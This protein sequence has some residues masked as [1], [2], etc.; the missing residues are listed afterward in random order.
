MDLQTIW[1]SAK[2]DG[3][4]LQRLDLFP[5]TTSAPVYGRESP[6]MDVI[7]VPDFELRKKKQNQMA[8]LLEVL[9]TTV[10][11]ARVFQFSQIFRRQT[12]SVWH[13]IVEAGDELVK[14]LEDTLDYV[15]TI[16]PLL[17]VSYGLGG[18]VLKKALHT[19]ELKD[20]PTSTMIRLAQ[21]GIV[22][23][24]VP[25]LTEHR[26]DLWSNLNTI[27]EVYGRFNNSY[28]GSKQD[29]LPLMADV[30]M[31]F[32]GLGSRSRILTVY[33]SEP[34]KVRTFPPKKKLLLGIGLAVLNMR[35]ETPFCSPTD[36]HGI[37]QFSHG[38]GLYNEISRLI[39]ICASIHIQAQPNSGTITM[40]VPNQID[41]FGRSG[42][43]WA[44][45]ESYTES[46]IGEP[47]PSGSYD[48]T[49]QDSGSSE[50]WELVVAEKKI[51][52]MPCYVRKAIDKNRNFVGRS[53]IIREIDQALLP[54][55]SN[56]SSGPRS[57]S[58][59]GFGGLGKTQIATYYAFARES[60]FDAIFWVQADELMK[61]NKSFEDIAKA[62]DLVEEG[63]QGNK[64]ISRD[65]VLEWFCEP[66]KR[67]MRGA[68]TQTD[69]DPALAKWLIIYDN[70]DDISIIREFWPISSCGSILVT[71]R[72]PT[73]KSD[74][75]DQG[76]DLPPMSSDEC[77]ALLQSLVG[78]TPSATPSQAA[79]SLANRIGNV[80]LAISQIATRIRCNAMT[81]EE[82]LNR[83]GNNSLLIELNKVQNLPPQEQY[84]HTLATVW[85]FENFSPKVQGLI[86]T[87]VFMDPDNI[88][89]FILQQ[90][91]MDMGNI[92]YPQPGDEYQRVWEEFYR[93][94]LVQ[95]KKETKS[96]SW[97]RE[98]Q[99]VAKNRMTDDQQ[100]KYYEHT[101]DILSRAWPYADDPFTRENFKQ[102]A[103][104][105]ILSHIQSI[106][107]VYKSPLTNFYI[108][109]PSARKL[110]KLLQEAGWYLVQSAQ[111]DPVLPMFDL[112]LSISQSYGDAMKDLFADTTFSL[113]RYGEETNM[114]PHKV[115]EYCDIYHR[116]SKESNDGSRARVQNLSTSHTSLAQAYLL[117]DNYDKAAEHCKKCIA[118][119]DDFPDHKSGAW[120]SQFAHIYLA[121]A[122]HGMGNYTK[123]ITL[124]S[125]VI[126]FRMH[127]FGPDD[128]ESIKLGLALHCLGNAR[129]SLGLHRES[130]EAY[131]KALVNFR[132]CLGPN[133]FRVGQMK[134]KL[135]EQLGHHKGF[136]QLAESFFNQAIRIFSATSY[137]SPELA[138]ALYKKYQFLVSLNTGSPNV[139]TPGP[140]DL[141]YKEAAETY[142]RLCPQA[143]KTTPLNGPDFDSLVRFWSR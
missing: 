32:W 68:A 6:N 81:I 52:K 50:S 129:Q 101:I 111:Y 123:A 37:C 33:E 113:A 139:T 142:H 105:D 8:S 51:P 46:A 49:A 22:F 31:K 94:S 60:D 21:Q 141:I 112:A 12:E 15:T 90:D 128:T 104:D 82:F 13:S 110:V 95:R 1:T 5:S 103:C 83:H 23:L 96:L 24:G 99:E 138:R 17:F 85:G 3:P 97:H 43:Y 54:N 124:A 122:E 28:L 126:E 59:C 117:L 48:A 25:Q 72:D 140:E 130:Q 108:S 86:H 35:D 20:T 63:D 2:V 41:I 98:V 107:R 40:T 135:A 132:A 45:T 136:G 39:Q 106:F 47:T 88:A 71:S 120:M 44:S 80:P 16:R 78:E 57:F 38:H 91:S 58:I 116:L 9:R 127:T 121:W 4:I 7:I 14:A 109:T 55:D 125:K 56:R 18:L 61:L 69:I 29:F 11:R 27:L 92:P 26:R 42:Y 100:Q 19:I 66:R 102:S 114:N 87:M 34:T 67:A 84:R 30:S 143:D 93:T 79:L 118:I 74:L 53:D 133:S 76:I 62:L 119:E 137:Y 131:R 64:A 77:A 70:A 89:E 115:F 36:F 10:P 75:A 73:A 134:L 65:K